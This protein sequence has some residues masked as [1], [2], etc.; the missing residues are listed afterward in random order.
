MSHLVPSQGYVRRDPESGLSLKRWYCARSGGSVEKGFERL[1]DVH[2][3]VAGLMHRDDRGITE[4]ALFTVNIVAVIDQSA[5][6]SLSAPSGKYVAR[7]SGRPVGQGRISSRTTFSFISRQALILQ[8][9]LHSQS[10]AI[11]HMQLK[12]T[13]KRQILGERN[14]NME[15]RESSNGLEESKVGGGRFQSSPSAEA[16]PFDECGSKTVEAVRGGA[17]QMSNETN[18]LDRVIRVGVRC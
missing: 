4:A 5:A 13:V 2:G 3:R 10:Q 18:D 17:C 9:A 12:I 1:A 16:S 8:H 7:R 11:S 15:A 14:D 6:P